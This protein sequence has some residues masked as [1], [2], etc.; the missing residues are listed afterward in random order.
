MIPAFIILYYLLLLLLFLDSPR[1]TREKKLANYLNHYAK[2]GPPYLTWKTPW[3]CALVE[4]VG[5][6]V[7]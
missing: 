7:Y 5:D 2:P 6:V 3:G 4:V 1:F